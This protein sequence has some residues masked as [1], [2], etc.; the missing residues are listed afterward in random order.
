MGCIVALLS[1]LLPAVMGEPN[2]QLPS[3]IGALWR[4]L[5]ENL[6]ANTQR[7]EAPMDL[8][9]D[10]LLLYIAAL[11]RTATCCAASDRPDDSL[12]CPH[13]ARGQICAILAGN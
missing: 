12:A 4:M 11:A 13:W 6:D 1:Y 5:H 2:S 9:P 10:L 8:S 7:A 3:C